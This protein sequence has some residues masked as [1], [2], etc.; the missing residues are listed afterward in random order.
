MGRENR[1][2]IKFI[3]I[4]FDVASTFAIAT[5]GMILN[6]RTDTGRHVAFDWLVNLVQN[7]ATWLLIG[8]TCALV[9]S[10]GVR[11]WATDRTTPEARL[12]SRLVSEELDRFRKTAFLGVP[13]HE[14][15][16]NNRVTIFRHDK[17]MWRIWPVRSFL[18]P[19]GIGRGPWSG[20]LVVAHRSGH[21]TQLRTSVFLAPDDAQAEGVAGQAWRGGTIRADEMPDLSAAAYV[22]VA[23]LALIWL[24]R[25]L[26]LADG[27]AR[28]ACYVELKRQVDAYAT[29]T[30]VHPSDVWSRIKRKSKL[31]TSIV[32]LPLHAPNNEPWGV[33]VMDSCNSV[34][35]MN[36]RS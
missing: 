19:W 4:G 22:S 7:S 15:H 3:A 10:R 13:G 26:K 14:P 28:H 23:G 29:G 31:P 18:W 17:K 5:I 11:R 32:A 25:Q 2:A 20:W 8:T 24:R 16:D 33:L 34:A 35:C 30:S 36:T 12:L 27:P 9:I 6:I 21:V 1:A